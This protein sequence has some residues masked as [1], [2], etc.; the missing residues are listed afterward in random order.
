MVHSTGFIQFKTVSGNT[1]RLPKYIG[2]PSDPDVRCRARQIH[3][4][5]WWDGAG[6]YEG[7]SDAQ[8]KLLGPDRKNSKFRMLEFFGNFAERPFL[9]VVPEAWKRKG[10]VQ[11][12]DHPSINVLPVGAIPA[13]RFIPPDISEVGSWWPAFEFR[14]LQDGLGKPIIFTCDSAGLK[15][16]RTGVSLQNPPPLPTYVCHSYFSV[17]DRFSGHIRIND[18]NFFVHGEQIIKEFNSKITSYI[19]K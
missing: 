14:H 18:P 8:A 2:T 6:F 17:S 11:L 15:K 4:R 1:L 19:L 7:I 10:V 3:L 12:A 16:G 13:E 9:P 5:L